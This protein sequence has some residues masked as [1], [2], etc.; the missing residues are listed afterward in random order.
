VE[1]WISADVKIDL[2]LTWRTPFEL[3][4][5]KPELCDRQSNYMLPCTDTPQAGVINTIPH[6]ELYYSIPCTHTHTHTHTHTPCIFLS[7]TLGGETLRYL[8]GLELNRGSVAVN[9]STTDQMSIDAWLERLELSTC[10]VNEAIPARVASLLPFM[11][12]G[13]SAKLDRS[14]L[15][16]FAP[17]G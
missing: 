6:C 16:S 11:C 15:S 13:S 9:S 1:Q 12:S 7:R 4:T 17:T 3:P 10:I 14:Q 5:F 8:R 2:T